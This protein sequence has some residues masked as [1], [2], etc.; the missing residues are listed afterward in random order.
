[1][2]VSR[3]SGQNSER[4]TI[5]HTDH[6]DKSTEQ[7][8]VFVTTFMK[9]RVSKLYYRRM[10]EQWALICVLWNEISGTHPR[11]NPNPDVTLTLTSTYPNSDSSLI[12]N[13]PNLAST[14]PNLTPTNPNSN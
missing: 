14:N 10:P 1:M 5:E 8:F 3:Y 2:L 9:S 11:T 12:L 13:K 4:T 6:R 7:R